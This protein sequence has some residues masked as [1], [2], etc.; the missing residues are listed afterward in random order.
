MALLYN[1]IIT[2]RVE[3]TFDI[4]AGGSLQIKERGKVTITFVDGAFHSVDFPFNG[5]YTRNGWR[6]LAAINDKIQ[7]I[8]M[9][10]MDI[11]KDK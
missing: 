10:M 3:Y 1:N 11:E 6:I 4:N 5:K 2:N 9:S 8:E 7:A